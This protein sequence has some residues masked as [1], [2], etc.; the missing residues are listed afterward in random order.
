MSN[1]GSTISTTVL[2]FN[3][4]P[5][6]FEVMV[7][8]CS[9]DYAS[10]RLHLIAAGADPNIGDSWYS[11]DPISSTLIPPGDST[12]FRVKILQ[13]PILGIDLINLEVQVSSPELP[14]INFH[15]L[16][17][18]VAAGIE[19]LRVYLPVNSFA[20]YPRKILDI[21]VRVSNPNHHQVDIILRLAGLDSRWLERGSERRL[22][23]GAGKEGETKFTCQPPIAKQTPCGIYPFTIKAYVNNEE[24]GSTTGTIEILPIGTVF[25]SVN[26]E[27]NILPS[28]SSWFPQ[29]KTKPALYQ[30]ELKN[31]SN[32]IQNQITVAVKTASKCDCQVIPAAGEAKPGETLNFKLEATKKRHWWGWKRKHSLKIIPSL[33]D[34]RLNTTDPTDKTVELQVRPLLPL[35][36]QLGLGAIAIA[37]ILYLLS[38]ISVKGHS[39]RVNSVTFS[40]DIDPILSGSEDG[41]VRKWQATPD[42]LFCQ[43]FNWQRFCLQHQTILLDSNKNGNLDR[44]NV[45]KLRSDNNL[46]GNLAFVGFDSGK[47][48]Q[49]K[50]LN[51]EAK[52]RIIL[53]GK[54]TD[55]L[56]SSAFNRIL[57]LTPSP[58]FKKIYLG[59]GT[60]LSQLNLT[61]K[62]IR[63]LIDFE[64]SIYVLTLTPDH[65]SI[66][67][68]GQYNKIFRVYL[69]NNQKQ[70]LALHRLLNEQND[71]ITGLKITENNLLISTD[72][73]GVINIWDLN[74]CEG[75]NCQLLYNQKEGIGINAIAL[76]KDESDNYYLAVAY[77]DGNIKVW[78]F[79][80]DVDSV[81]LNL[82]STINYPQQITSIDLIYQEIKDR[83]RLL[84][85]SGSQDSKVRLNIHQIPQ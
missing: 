30:L 5:I 43:W 38:L 67:A 37:L 65:Q 13:T 81:E 72:N 60:K 82:E 78:S 39:D 41:T 18:Y 48:S 25:F 63:D 34:L 9:N 79:S 46:S 8:N 76:T 3:D 56:N 50:I 52:E 71:Q 69:S 73:R 29:F 15:N 35:W 77:T 42:N 16:K 19:K 55:N 74:L 24:W 11:L 6:S 59:R 26:P 83:K 44:V 14:D 54:N 49:L 33:T 53:K 4:A 22:I 68:G 84:I 2:H 36:L 45:V 12:K 21:P 61:Q 80:D 75:K 47:V 66:I 62:K 20:I 27:S 7:K 28:K 10:F 51:T 23:I 70:E 64:I 32:V 31:A 40:S 58:D 17:L 57:N 1:I 85:L